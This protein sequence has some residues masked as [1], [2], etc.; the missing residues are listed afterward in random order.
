VVKLRMFRAGTR[1]PSLSRTEG[2]SLVPVEIFIKNKALEITAP[3]K[4]KLENR[5]KTRYTV[6]S[7]RFHLLQS[8]YSSLNIGVCNRD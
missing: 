4:I 5:Y 8:S 3:D 7:D 1:M 2:K 6:E